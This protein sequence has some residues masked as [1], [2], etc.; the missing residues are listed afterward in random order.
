MMRPEETRITAG[1]SGGFRGWH[2]G[3]FPEDSGIG[4]DPP[5][6]RAPGMEPAH[7]EARSLV[8]ARQAELRIR[9]GDVQEVVRVDVGGVAGAATDHVVVGDAAGG[10]RREG[11]RSAAGGGDVGD[12]V[13]GDVMCGLIGLVGILDGAVV[14]RG[15]ELGGVLET[16]GGSPGRSIG[17]E[18][19]ILNADGVIVGEIAAAADLEAGGGDAVGVIGGADEMG[20]G[21]DV[22][23]AP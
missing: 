5:C 21:G 2:M 6:G 17:G 18:A 19:R 22:L 23:P 7:G 13:G 20:P 14:G 3:S 12:A 11:N 1:T 15:V 10:G 16:A 8:M 4:N 9:V